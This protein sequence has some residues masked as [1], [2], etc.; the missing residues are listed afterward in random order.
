MEVVGAEERSGNNALTGWREWGWQ[1]SNLRPQH[2]SARRRLRWT[3]M[4]KAARQTRW[5]TF[6][7]PPDP[8]EGAMDAPW[9]SWV[10]PQPTDDVLAGLAR[11]LD[12]DDALKNEKPRSDWPQSWGTPAR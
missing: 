5:R 10:W 8:G 12:V 6:T 2:Q 1:E 3:A 4:N 7:N 11:D 9:K